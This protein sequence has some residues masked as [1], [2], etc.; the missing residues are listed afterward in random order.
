MSD[1]TTVGQNSPFGPPNYCLQIW[2]TLLDSR[3]GS[4]PLQV[5]SSGGT[6]ANSSVGSFGPFGANR[7]EILRQILQILTEARSGAA[8]LVTKSV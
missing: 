4:S 3:N 7:P 6:P 1:I 5:A 2:Q 8:P